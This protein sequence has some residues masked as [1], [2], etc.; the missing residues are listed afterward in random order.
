[1]TKET[2][3]KSPSGRVK[4][5][6]I[7]KRNILSV[8]NKDPNYVYRVVNDTGDRIAAFEEAGYV[9]CEA[10]EVKVGDKRVERVSSEGS[11]AQVAVGK[12]DKAFVM[13]ILKEYYDEDQEAKLQQVRE[14][15]KSIKPTGD[16]KGNKLEI[17]QG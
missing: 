1:M 6:P 10:S 4:R 3:A 16:Y 2:I 9:V 8:A 11:K 7:G 13:K 12:G 15:E 17:S 5:T 14:L